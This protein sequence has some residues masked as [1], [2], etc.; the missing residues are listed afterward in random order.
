VVDVAASITNDSSVLSL[1]KFLG[2]AAMETEGARLGIAFA[3]VVLAGLCAPLGASVV[4]F[5]KKSHTGLLAASIA[6]AAGVMLFVS[7]T[8]VRQQ[9]LL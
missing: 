4:V 2:A 1:F 6:L 8:E 7:L 3:L 5:M 9:L